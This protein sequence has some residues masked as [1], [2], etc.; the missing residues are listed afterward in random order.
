MHHIIMKFLRTL[1]RMP[2]TLDL[3]V[4]ERSLICATHNEGVSLTDDAKRYNVAQSSVARINSKFKET[5]ILSNLS[6]VR[7]H[8]TTAC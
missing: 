4:A 2:K 5:S 8:S 3:T 7:S 1:Y 6:S